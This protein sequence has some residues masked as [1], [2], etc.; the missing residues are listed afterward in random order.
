MRPRE[1]SRQRRRIR[2]KKQQCFITFGFDQRWSSGSLL[3]G[4][5]SRQGGFDGAAAADCCVFSTPRL[6]FHSGGWRDDRRRVRRKQIN[7]NAALIG[8]WPFFHA[9]TT[10]DESIICTAADFPTPQSGLCPL[11]R[12]AG[13]KS[14]PT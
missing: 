11:H 13:Q 7:F 12:S 6:L 8:L 2:H 9:D 5:P 1:R 3:L 14:I 10:R 4:R